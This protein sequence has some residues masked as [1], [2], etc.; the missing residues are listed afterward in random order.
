MPIL[1]RPIYK[2]PFWQFGGH[3]QTIIPSLFRK[4]LFSYQLRER[5]ELTDGDFVDL[6]WHFISA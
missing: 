5:L 3:L 6:D 2:T 1:P 4:V